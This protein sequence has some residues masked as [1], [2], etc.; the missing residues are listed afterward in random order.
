VPIFEYRCRDCGKSFEFLQRGKDTP[1]CPACGSEN[2]KK[3]L[4]SFNSKVQGDGNGRGGGC[5]TCSGGSCAT[6]GK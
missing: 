3:L 5:A 1:Q 6:C 4:S 2:L